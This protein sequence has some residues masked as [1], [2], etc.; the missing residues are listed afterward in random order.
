MVIC[1]KIEERQYKNYGK[2]LFICNGTV[3]I[4]VTLDIGPRIIRFAFLDGENEFFEEEN[5][6]K[7]QPTEGAWTKFGDEGV[8]HMYGG[9]RFWIS[10]EERAPYIL[11]RQ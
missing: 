6:D 9:H 2:C 8:W 11:S 10:P 7:Q 5:F 4:A 1:I 3:E